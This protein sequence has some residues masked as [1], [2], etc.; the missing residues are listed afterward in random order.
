[1]KVFVL[2]DYD[3]IQGIYS[4]MDLAE[5]AARRT[6]C[7]FRPDEHEVDEPPPELVDGKYAW[8]V[9]LI[10]ADGSVAWVKHVAVGKFRDLKG[11]IWWELAE[12]VPSRPAIGFHVLAVT[13][14]EAI[15]I[16]KK[17][18]IDQLR[19]TAEAIEA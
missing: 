19:A 8:A 12:G 5:E 9:C 6:G 1:M 18:Y 10:K 17:V 16:V 15:A 2:A 14:D 4:T 13:G 11:P 7:K 3:G